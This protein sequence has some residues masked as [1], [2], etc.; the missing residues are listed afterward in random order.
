[1]GQNKT[2]HK[3]RIIV[4]KMWIT[5][6]GYVPGF[7]YIEDK[8]PKSNNMEKTIEIKKDSS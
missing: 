5:K 1:M 7:T 4:N 6:P 8:N 3:R 2:R